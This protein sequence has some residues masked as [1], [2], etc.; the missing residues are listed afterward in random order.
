VVRCERS[1]FGRLSE[2]TTLT[3]SPGVTNPETCLVGSRAMETAWCPSGIGSSRR[4]DASPLPTQ[5]A[6]RSCSPG[7]MSTAATRPPSCSRERTAPVATTRR[8]SAARSIRP[9]FWASSPL[10]PAAIRERATY[11]S[12]GCWPLTARRSALPA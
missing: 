7:T 4:P 11:T 3:R 9:R 8:G 10:V 5:R 12:T 2:T 1:P 6:A